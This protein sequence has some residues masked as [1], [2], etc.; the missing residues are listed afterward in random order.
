M[1]LTSDGKIIF[2]VFIGAIIAIVLISSIG[3]QINVVTTEGVESNL[4]VNSSA[5]GNGTVS[6]IGRTLLVAGD[7]F[8]ST[9]NE[10]G[11][12]EVFGTGNYTL[13]T[14]TISGS[15][16]VVLITNDSA[17]E[18]GQQLNVTYTY[19]PDGYGNTSEARSIT[20]LILI[21]SALAILMFVV[22]MIWRQGG[23]LS[24]LLTVGSK[25]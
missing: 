3:D 6:L 12:A 14:R 9:G 10:S 7:I 13:A 18:P 8:N 25:R 19:E 24:Q 15:R 4:T 20:T 1:A 22:V 2:G 11:H 17:T 23:S 16:T 5:T 21:I